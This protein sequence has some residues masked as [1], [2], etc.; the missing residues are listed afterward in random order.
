MVR[1][2]QV[3]SCCVTAYFFVNKDIMQIFKNIFLACS[4]SV[5]AAAPLVVRAEDTDAQAAARAA[6]EQKMRE[7][8][9]TSAPVAAPDMV[10]TVMPK[11]IKAAP[12]ATQSE[13]ATTPPK[14]Q[15]VNV[16]T[17]GAA[18]PDLIEQAREATRARMAE[19]Q[20]QK[21]TQIP[22]GRETPATQPAQPQMETAPTT[23]VLN[24]GAPAQVQADKASDAADKKI[25][26]ARAEADAKAAKKAKKDEKLEV[27]APLAPLEGPASS[28]PTTTEQRLQQLTDKYKADQITAE[29]YHEQRAKILAQ[30]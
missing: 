14:S 5:V 27:V 20:A 8:S 15:P 26:K 18:S 25:A 2:E 11:K 21:A 24:S 9:G 1:C 10:P 16:A 6:L 12:P 13:P 30:P 17:P 22:V 28:L 19:L 29:E 4:I 3:E 23:P 7:I